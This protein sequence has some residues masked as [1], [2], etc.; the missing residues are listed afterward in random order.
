MSKLVSFKIENVQNEDMSEDTVV[1][2]DNEVIYKVDKT[3]Y[4]GKY[5]KKCTPEILKILSEKL[6]RNVTDRD[7]NVAR[8]IEQI[9]DTSDCH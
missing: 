4:Y 6:G 2:L 7:L 9:E 5:R 3:L 8:I 1:L